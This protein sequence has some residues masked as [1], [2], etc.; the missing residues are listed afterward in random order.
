[1]TDASSFAGVVLAGGA[2]RRMGSDKALLT[3]GGRPLVLRATNALRD[4]GAA[5]VVVVGGGAAVAALV[6][7]HV[8]DAAPG[9]GP[10]VALVQSLE[11]VAAPVVVA[12][13]CDLP[14]IEPSEI[15]RLVEVLE[16]GPAAVAV[17][18]VDGRR[19]WLHAAW[20][21]GALPELAAAAAA[22]ERSLHRAAAGLVIVEVEPAD[23][24]AVRDVDRPHD[25]ARYAE[26]RDEPRRVR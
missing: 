23:P 20:R 9:A 8:A 4:A 21:R 12:V 2:S 19:Q 22:G 1:M 5:S 15:S 17:S 11:R 16:A 25:L 13:A 7:D 6:D 14:A 3:L 10:L 26:R 24:D 18:V